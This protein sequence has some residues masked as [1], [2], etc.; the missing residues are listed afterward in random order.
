M[1]NTKTHRMIVAG[2]R[3]GNQFLVR[4]DLVK[5]D[6]VGGAKQDIP[7]SWGL[8]HDPLGAVMS[9]CDIRIGPYRSNGKKAQIDDPVMARVARAYF[10]HGMD[11][12]GGSVDIPDG[13]WQRV[14]RVEVVYYARYG[15]GRF[16]GLFRHQIKMQAPAVHL[17]KLQGGNGFRLEFPQGCI[18]DSH[19]FVWP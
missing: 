5:F 16:N 7:D 17:M 9:P 1:G 15:Q 12:Y 13:K 3:V 18:I 11:I 6:L 2:D 14:G 19:G 4:G 10:G 8:I